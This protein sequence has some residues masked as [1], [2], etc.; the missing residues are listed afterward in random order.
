MRPPTLAR[1]ALALALSL[2]VGP[3]ARGQDDEAGPPE[4]TADPGF[5]WLCFATAVTAL[6]GGYVLVR[7][8]EQAA[9]DEQRRG[10]RPAVPWYCRACDRDVTGPACPACGAPNPFLHDL[11][12]GDT[13]PRPGRTV[14]RPSN[15]R[16]GGPPP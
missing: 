9:E 16:R 5:P 7:R 8:R 10:R 2:T 13:G 12:A 4:P 3:A 1:L 14:S 11:T 6:A 15:G